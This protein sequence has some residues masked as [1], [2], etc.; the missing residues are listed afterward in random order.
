MGSKHG[1][2]VPELVELEEDQDC[3]EEHEGGVK[4]EVCRGW[5]D[6]VDA[7]ENS[8][9]CESSTQSIEDPNLFR[10]SCAFNLFLAFLKLESSD[11]DFQYEIET[12]NTIPNVAEDMP[13]ICEFSIGEQTEEV[14]VTNI[15]ITTL[16]K[17]VLVVEDHLKC[18]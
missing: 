5:A 14:V 2:C 17:G 13:K 9:Q 1:V 18:W 6:V 8:F 3:D 7:T 10:Y 15:L 16:Y 4:L 12:S 11:V